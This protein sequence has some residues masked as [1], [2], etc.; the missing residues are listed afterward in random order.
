MA[1]SQLIKDLVTDNITI[2]QALLRVKVISHSLKNNVLEEWIENEINGYAVEDVVPG[3]RKKAGYTIKY[4]G[5][6]GRAEVKNGV[7]QEQVFPKEIQE[8]LRNT[9]IRDGVR[10]V[11]DVLSGDKLVGKDLMSIAGVVHKNSGGAIQCVS[12]F[13]E[14]SRTNYTQIIG[15]IKNNLLSVML[16]MEDQFGVLDS[17]DIDTSQKSCEEI[18]EINKEINN[19]IGYDGKHEEL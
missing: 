18:I 3:Y 10:T 1:K 17:L 9:D 12:L 15:A 5:F 6:N 2:E 7:L 8:L 14:L 13:Q 16:K 4:S 19:V 11:E